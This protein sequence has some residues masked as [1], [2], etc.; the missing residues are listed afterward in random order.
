MGPIPQN[1]ADA[2]ALLDG[3]VQSL[4]AGVEGGVLEADVSNGRGID[5]G[6]QLAGVVHEQAVEEIHVLMLDGRE[7]EVL[8]NVCLTSPDHLHGALALRV[9]VLHDVRQQ[10]REVLGDTLLRSEGKT[11]MEGG[12]S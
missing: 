11:Y 5:Q 7:V 10:T 3:D 9:E 12:V 2:L 1:S 8:V 6:H 4:W